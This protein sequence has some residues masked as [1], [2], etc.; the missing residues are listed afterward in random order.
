MTET[1]HLPIVP[2]TIAVQQLEIDEQTGGLRVQGVDLESGRFTT[3]E[4][5]EQA[6]LTSPEEPIC[7][8]LLTLSL[9][10]T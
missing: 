3:I 6:N 4:I 2:V 5:R 1:T 9:Q 7:G 8:L 10:S